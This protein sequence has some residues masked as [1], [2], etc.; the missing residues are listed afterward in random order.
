MKFLD[1]V[2][3]HIKA[4]NGGSGA[5]S[6][7]REK[8]V[9]FGGPDGGDGGRGGSVIFVTDKNLNTLIDFRYQQHF[10]AERGQDGKGKKQTGKNGKDLILKVPIGTQIF[11]SD[12]NTLIKDL[13]HSEEKIIIANGGKGGLGNV[14]FK[15]SI[16]R[17]PRKKTEGRKGE[18]FWIWLQLKVIADVGIVGMP[19]SGKSSLLTALTNARPKIANYPFTTTNPNLG[20]ADYNNKE[21]TL[22]DIPGLIEGAHEGTGL[23]DKFLMHIERCKNILH[24]IDITNDNLF[25]NYSKIRKELFKYSNKLTKKRE[26]IVFNKIDMISNEEI[27]KKINIFNKKIKKKIYAISAL[28]HKGLTTIKKILVNYVH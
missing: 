10:K 28:K 12:N 1:Q 25:E 17:A 26:I 4:G 19:N 2:K 5:A 27:D 18:D 7:R 15:S 13:T 23:G 6:F 14:R 22:A 24:L 3:I 9:E 8:F 21:V 16:N 20:V 11:E